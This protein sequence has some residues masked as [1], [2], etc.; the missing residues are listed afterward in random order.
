MYIVDFIIISLTGIQGKVT[1]T[2]TNIFRYSHASYNDNLCPNMYVL[3]IYIYMYNYVVMPSVHPHINAQFLI[4]GGASTLA[5][6]APN[7]QTFK[8]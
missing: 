4:W 2:D 1:F 5:T 3:Y 6:G 7:P 8:Y